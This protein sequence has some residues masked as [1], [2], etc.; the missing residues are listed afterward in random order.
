MLLFLG[1]HFSISPPALSAVA[2]TF[3]DKLNLASVW[4][5]SVAAQRRWAGGRRGSWD[6]GSILSSRGSHCALSESQDLF[7][8]G[9]WRLLPCGTGALTISAVPLNQPVF[10]STPFIQLSPVTLFERR[11][12]DWGHCPALVS[13][14]SLAA[15]DREPPS[16]PPI[17]PHCPSHPLPPCGCCF[18]HTLKWATSPVP[19]T[20]EQPLSQ[21]P[22]KSINFCFFQSIQ[23]RIF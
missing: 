11:D 19:A 17:C 8:C 10:L 22:H 14:A 20:E 23:C 9:C 13:T 2:T 12:A 5:P 15:S 21:S 4:G 16:P 3:A 1:L 7:S 6:P 18:L